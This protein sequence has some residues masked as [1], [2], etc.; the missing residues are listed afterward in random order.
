MLD[1][2]Y[3]LYN[4]LKLD[5]HPSCPSFISRFE[6]SKS[7]FKRDI[8]FLRDRLGAPIEY[9]RERASYVLTDTSF[10]LPPYWFD[11][12]Q[13]FLILGLCRQFQ[14][15][16]RPEP[17]EIRNLRCR[18]EE[19][20]SIHYG[21]DILDSVSFETIQWVGFE[22]KTMDTVLEAIM[23][24]RL[25]S[26]IYNTAHSGET[27]RRTIEP[28]R[29]HNYMGAWH[30]LGY[31]LMRKCPRMFLLSRIEDPRLINRRFSRPRF[32]PGVYLADTFGIYK[33]EFTTRV[34]LRFTPEIARFVKDEVWHRDQEIRETVDGGII[35]SLPV[36]DL[37][38]IRRHVL[39]Y[40]SRVEVIEPE[41]L[42]RQVAEE[43]ISVASLYGA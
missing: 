17:E 43:A 27:T 39:K 13:L 41:E 38:E 33:G 29:L 30:V 4:Q 26:M 1:R 14:A 22:E 42:R 3:W 35:L 25:M 12:V 11:R 36:S 9:D 24:K 40:G 6:V 15:A 2:I 16:K 7:T 23:E 18:A 28:Y 5:K 31:C 32:D 10:R 20:L 21:R 37:T 19:I 8:A 34:V